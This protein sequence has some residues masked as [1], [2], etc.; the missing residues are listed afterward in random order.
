MVQVAKAGRVSEVKKKP[1]E[2]AEHP[3]NEKTELRAK[4][5]NAIERAKAV[6]ERLQEQTSE[7]ATAADKT[8]RE[9]PYQAMGIAFGVGVLIGV[10]VSRR[11]D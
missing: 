4:L 8:V 10:L 6:C 3:E 7:A 5:D 2:T 11:N 1:M 9:H